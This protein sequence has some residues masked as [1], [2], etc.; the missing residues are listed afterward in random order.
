M[1]LMRVI[2]VVGAPEPEVAE[3]P[4]GLGRVGVAGSPVVGGAEIAFDGVGVGVF[5]FAL[6]AGGAAD[7]D[8]AAVGATDADGAG[9]ANRVGVAVAAGAAVDGDATGVDAGAEVAVL[10]AAIGDPLEVQPASS[11][12]DARTISEEKVRRRVARRPAAARRAVIPGRWLM[13]TGPSCR[14][15]W[16]RLRFGGSVRAKG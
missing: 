5:G 3:A 11:A 10:G 2:V 8:G 13:R 14:N 4:E 1:V 7:A 16:F 15:R 12:T 9:I 6:E